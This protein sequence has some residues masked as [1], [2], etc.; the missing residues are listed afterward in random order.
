MARE[1][2]LTVTNT[3]ISVLNK[4]ECKMESTSK[5]L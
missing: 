2:Q 4:E 5:V 1:Y 3:F